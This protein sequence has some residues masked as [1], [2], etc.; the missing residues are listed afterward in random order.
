MELLPMHMLSYAWG[1]SFGDIVDTLVDFCKTNKLSTESTYIWICAFCN[2]QHR[3]VERD[4]PFEDFKF[5]FNN[6]VKGIGHIL[7]MM[8]PWE[9]P[10]YLKR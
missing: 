10:G 9:D 6:R 3:V 4:V 2:N 1:Y 5:V 8:T 7:A